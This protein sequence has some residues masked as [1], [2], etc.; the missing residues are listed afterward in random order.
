[1]H[2]VFKY[3]VVAFLFA[4]FILYGLA[5]KLFITEPIALRRHRVKTVQK[6]A[7]LGARVFGLEISVK[8]PERFRAGQNYLIV[9]NHLSYLDGII[10][11]AFAPVC[12]ITSVEMRQ[13]FF[14]GLITE[15][16]GCLYVER[17]SREKIGDEISEITT[18]LREGFNVVIFPEATSTNGS[19]VLPFKRSLLASA[20][21]ADR[22]LLPL[23]INY[24]FIDGEPVT[25][26]NRD[27]LCWYGDMNFG[28]HFFKFVGLSK[29]E[30]SLHLLPEIASTG[31]TREEL[32]ESA[33][34][35]IAKDYVPI[36]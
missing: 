31:R 36:L 13:A 23:T 28:P 9:G 3:A 19:S 24:N 27:L 7:R 1:M 29:I 4:A 32:S 5:V 30:I 12:F 34:S 10:L 35:A 33:Y 20:V 6:F 16:A 2:K 8:D 15:L 17:R 11:G 18:A 25:A 14:L 26:K 21:Q 22:P